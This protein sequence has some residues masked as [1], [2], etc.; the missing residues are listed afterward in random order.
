[1]DWSKVDAAVRDIEDKY[2]AEQTHPVQVWMT[3]TEACLHYE[4][5]IGEDALYLNKLHVPFGCRGK[6]H[7]KEA[8]RHLVQVADKH[9]VSVFVWPTAMTWVC[10]PPLSLL[11]LFTDKFGLSQSGLEGFYIRFGFEYHFNGHWVRRPR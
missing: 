1:M 7:A 3:R 9:G 2:P 8:M 11:T 5:A 4:D 6:G 10:L